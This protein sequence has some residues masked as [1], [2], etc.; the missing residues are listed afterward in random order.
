MVVVFAIVAVQQGLLE[1]A[2]DEPEAAEGC[3][4]KG[5]T[6][7]LQKLSIMMLQI[8]LFSFHTISRSVVFPNIQNNNLITQIR[9]HNAF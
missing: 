7:L 4:R 1:G 2:V 3:E 9:K 5:A 8:L 6:T